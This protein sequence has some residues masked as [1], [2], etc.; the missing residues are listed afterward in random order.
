[1]NFLYVRNQDSEAAVLAN[2]ISS[3]RGDASR[4]I[5]FQ[6]SASTL[7]LRLFIQKS[8]AREPPQARR[9]L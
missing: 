4:N 8:S 9:L 5:G 3:N 1:M 7:T 6:A 2:S